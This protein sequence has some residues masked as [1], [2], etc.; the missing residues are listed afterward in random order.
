MNVT[1]FLTHHSPN[2]AP[3]IFSGKLSVKVIQRDHTKKDGTKPL[4]LQIFLNKSRKLIQLPIAVREGD[5]DKEKQRVKSKA[6]LAMD[7]NLIIEKALADLNRIEVA[8]RLGN[9]GLTL[10]KLTEEFENPS[11]RIDFINFWHTELEAQKGILKPGTYKQQ[12]SALQK[13]R[14]FK[15]SILFYEVTPEL[16]VKLKTYLKKRGNQENTIGTFMKSFKKFLHLAN[17]KGIITPL[18]YSKIE[19]RQFK[20]DRTFLTK[21]ELQKLN[22]YFD[23]TFINASHRLVLGGFLFCCFAG[24]RVSDLQ[25]LSWD[26]VLENFIVF[27]AEKTAKLQ[28]VALNNPARKFLPFAIDMKFTA[29]YMNRE[30]KFI[31]KVCGI[32]KKVTTHV[33]RH[34]FATQFLISGG[35]VEHLQKLLGHSKITETMIYVQIVDSITD[36][37]IQ[38]MDHLL[39]VNRLEL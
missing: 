39:D 28:R 32:D 15:S 23:S 5:F 24:L 19:S 11:G 20:S 9:Q 29:E 31:T 16:M 17:E 6:P 1:A 25:K 18:V 10:E 14:Q 26:N 7:Y 21:Q 38:A 37:Q 3:M 34:T 2:N 22:E 4:W 36:T 13:L 12:K 35:R 27:T 8:Y 30:L 33:A